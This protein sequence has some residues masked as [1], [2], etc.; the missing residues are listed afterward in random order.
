MNVKQTKSCCRRPLA[1]SIP[2]IFAFLSPFTVSVLGLCAVLPGPTRVCAS[3]DPQYRSLA[4]V[5]FRRPYI[6]SLASGLTH[7]VAVLFQN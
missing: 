1:I 4:L 3:G 6:L 5:S 7:G 2:C